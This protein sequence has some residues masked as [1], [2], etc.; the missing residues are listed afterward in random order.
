MSGAQIAASRVTGPFA[1]VPVI[2]AFASA[3]AG[4]SGEPKPTQFAQFKVHMTSY[5]VKPGESGCFS[6]TVVTDPAGMPNLP[7]K[8]VDVTL[9]DLELLQNL[10]FDEKALSLSFRHDQHIVG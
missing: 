8:Q 4:E 10:S 2:G 3:L 7:L 6:F 5:K 1:G 9:R